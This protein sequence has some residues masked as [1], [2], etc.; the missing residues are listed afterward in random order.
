MSNFTFFH[1]DFYAICI[2][3]ILN[4][5]I[6]VV[7]CCFFEFGTVSNWCTR[8]SVNPLP[9]SMDFLR[10]YKEEGLWKHYWEKE[11]N[12]GN[13]H[14]FLFPNYFLPSPSQITIFIVKFILPSGHALNFGQSKSSSWWLWIKV[15]TQKY[16]ELSLISSLTKVYIYSTSHNPDFRR[17]QRIGPLKTLREKEKMLVTSTFSFSLSVFYSI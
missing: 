3:K 2:L 13:Q 11:Q 5:H 6:P 8:E 12:A 17:P 15:H 10:P 7:V 16:I 1:N 9:H 14:F 4:S